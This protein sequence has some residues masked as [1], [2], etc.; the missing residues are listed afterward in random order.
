MNPSL[1]RSHHSRL[2]DPIQ[3]DI[4]LIRISSGVYTFSDYAWFVALKGF[5][6][7]AD[8]FRSNR[9]YISHV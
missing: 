9:L 5:G 4:T 1:R 2:F 7:P 8:V 6:F 3:A